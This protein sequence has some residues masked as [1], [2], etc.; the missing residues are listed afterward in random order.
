MTTTSAQSVI[1]KEHAG[2]NYTIVL[3]QHDSSVY[4]DI[5]TLGLHHHQVKTT[6]AADAWSDLEKEGDHAAFTIIDLHNEAP[7]GLF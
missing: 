5:D 3:K 2:L 7:K 4:L 1:H 6:C